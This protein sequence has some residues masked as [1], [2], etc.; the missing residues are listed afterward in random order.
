MVSLTDTAKTLAFTSNLD[1]DKVIFTKQTTELWA[2]GISNTYTYSTGLQDFCFPLA[3]YSLDGV[4]WYEQ[5]HTDDTGTY[6]FPIAQINDG[7]TIFIVAGNPAV[8]QT[9]YIRL[10]C[11]AQ[12]NQKPFNTAFNGNLLAYSS[13][14]RY[15]KI[16]KTDMIHVTNNGAIETPTNIVIPHDLNYVPMVRWFV[17]FNN[18]TEWRTRQLSNAAKPLN[19]VDTHNLYFNNDTTLGGTNFVVGGFVDYYYTIYLDTI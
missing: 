7:G 9:L 19:S 18:G 3:L 6:L 17:R 10:F 11:L 15:M 16:L 1:T 4:K 2:H 5:G 14:F 8:T 13:A 12:P